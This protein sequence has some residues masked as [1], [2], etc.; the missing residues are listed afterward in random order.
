MTDSLQSYL[1][2]KRTV[3]DRALNRRV[4][5]RFADE[6]WRRWERGGD[7]PVRIVEFGAGIGAMVARL[8]TWGLLPPRVTYRAIEID[9]ASVAY[10]ESNLPQWLESSGFDVER[11]ADGFHVRSSPDRSLDASRDGHRHSPRTETGSETTSATGNETAN[12]TEGGTETETVS[13]TETGTEY[14]LEITV[15]TADAFAIEDEADAVIAAAFLDVVDLDSALDHLPSVL[16][17]DG[18]LYAPVT[19]DGETAFQPPTSND[20][21]VTDLYHRHMDELRDR[22]GSA[23]TGRALLTALPEAGFDVLAAGG[24]D[25]IV[26]STDGAYPHDERAFLR[27]LVETVDGALTDYP[28]DELDPD[29]RRE[30][31][32]RRLNQLDRRDLV[33][34]AHHVDVLGTLDPGVR[35]R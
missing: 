7:D 27:N 29:V 5:S 1:D 3:D 8:V 30:W 6:L 22:P 26:R 10:A 20:E 15:E 24:A 18:L 23:R 12:R 13:R 17:A 2:A 4:V 16:A 32:S 21:L 34:V 19:F 33:L 31:T 25:W 9:G 35:Q 14:R 11:T 28:A